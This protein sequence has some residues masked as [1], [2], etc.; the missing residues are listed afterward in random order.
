MS[1]SL[2]KTRIMVECALMIA[3][4]TILAYI[5]FIQLPQGGSVTLCSMLPIMVVGWRHG[6]KWGLFTGLVH[7]IIQM[8]LGFQNVMYCTTIGSMA[9]CILLDYIIAFSVL[10]AVSIV[11]KPMKNSLAGIACS[12]VAVG[13]GR[14]LCSFLSG[15][16][17]WGGY[18]PEGTPVWIYSLTYNGSYMIP[19]IIITTVAAVLVAKLVL[20]RLPQPEAR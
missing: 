17:I 8:M 14:Y 15:I 3:L 4:A 10:G 5:P 7:G 19:E 6:L 12:A 11:S 16:L 13:L 1:K 20:P 18:A 2:T 9:L